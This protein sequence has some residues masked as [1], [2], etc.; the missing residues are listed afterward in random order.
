[1]KSNYVKTLEEALLLWPKREV[2]RAKDFTN[3]KFNKWTI[4][5]RTLDPKRPMWVGQ[6]ECGNFGKLRAGEWSQQCEECQYKNS[7]KDYTG[8]KFNLL[9][10]L[11]EREVRNKKTYLKCRCD[12]GNETWVSAG[13]LTSGEVKSCGC[14]SYQYNGELEDLTGKIYNDLTVLNFAFK[15]DGQRYWHCKCKCGNEKD[16]PTVALTQEKV[17]SCGCRRKYLDIQPGDKFGRLTVQSRIENKRS[18]NGS[19]LYSCDCDCGTKNHIVAGPYLVNGRIKSCGCGRNISYNEENIKNLLI[20]L[21]L[22]FIKDYN[23]IQL[24]KKYPTHGR[25]MEY[26]FY[27]NDSYMIEYDGSQHFFAKGSGWDTEQNLQQTRKNDLIKNKFCFENNIPLIRIP[28]NE[29]YTINDLKLET[30]R[31]LLTPE[32]ENEY[33]ESRA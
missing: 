6:C 8:M 25:P 13:N 26:D 18:L 15:K 21:N 19:Y 10:V 24:N 12:C 5:Y 20:Q 29:E 27:V 31:F 2:G 32:N 22:P 28:Y 3:Q 17:K 9:T 33:Y 16:I 23:N 1:M 4:L 7:Q 11:N 30:T 14:L